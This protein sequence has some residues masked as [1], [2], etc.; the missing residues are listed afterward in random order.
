M[1]A[2]TEPD[3]I[4]H[5]GESGGDLRT[6]LNP[7]PEIPNQGA[8]PKPNNPPNLA[9]PAP[10]R[11][12][13]YG[14]TNKQ[15]RLRD[16][17]RKTTFYSQNIQGSGRCKATDTPT[18]KFDHI[19]SLMKAKGID[20]YLVQ[21][22]WLSNEYEDSSDINGFYL[23]HHGTDEEHEA[24]DSNEGEDEE[25]PH[26][27]NKRKQ[28]HT[29]GG[30]AIF[31]SPRAKEAWKRAGQQDPITSGNI[32]GCARFISISL[33]FLD[34][35][36]KTIKVNACSI[37]HPTDVTQ[38]ERSD[39]LSD[40][41]SLYDTLD[42]DNH[43]IISGCDANAS[44]GNRNSIYANRDG[45]VEDHE[46]NADI[47]G[48]FGLDHVNEAGLELSHLMKSKKLAS[49]TS[50]FE[51]KTYT[52]WRSFSK[53]NE[54]RAQDGEP[55]LTSPRRVQFQLDLFLTQKHNLKSIL[56]AKRVGDGAP[57]D[58]S[59]VKLVLRLA[60][61]LVMKNSKFNVK[62]VGKGKKTAKLDW[63]LLRN[64]EIRANYNYK[65]TTNLQKKKY[66]YT[67]S[68]AIPTAE[69][70]YTDFM[71]A[72]MQAAE[73]TIQGPG[74]VSKDWFQHSEAILNEAIRLRNYWSSVWMHTTL[75]QARQKFREARSKL[76]KAIKK[77]KAVWID[78]RA[79]EIHDMKFDPKSAWMAVREVE[80]GFEGHYSA[81]GDIKMR[82]PNGDIAT[83]DREN[84]DVMAEH[85]KKVFNN[86]RPIDISVLDEL[87]QREII[88]ELGLPPTNEEFAAA[89]RKIANGKSPG[90]SGITPEA[91]KNLDYSHTRTLR[92]FLREYWT[93]PNVDYEEWHRNSLCALRKAGKGKDYS[94][95]NNWR[96]ICLAEIPAK[97]QSSII[98]NR[99]L[100][101][102]EKVGIETQYGCVPGKGCTDALYAIKTALQIRKQHGKDTWAVFVD[103][104]KAFDTAD[105]SLL[106]AIL[107][108][109]GIPD[110]LISVIEKMY[111]DSIVSFKIGSESRDIKYGIG[112]KQG[113]NM[114]P[115]L[116]IYLMNAFAETLADKWKFDKLEFRW[117]PETSSVKK[118]GRL[119]GQ[120]PKTLGTKFDLFYFLYVDDGAM[121]FDN[122]NDLIEGTRLI[123]NHFARFGLEMHIG[124][125]EKK[126][127]TECV[128]F[129]AFESEYEDKDTSIFE[130][131]D[132]FVQF[133]KQFKYLGSIISF[134][135]N[136]SID[137][138]ARISQASKAM[139][140]L[141]NFF[142]CDKVS[143]YAKRLIY[144]AIPVNLCL[145]GAE[146]WALTEASLRKL[147]VFHTRSIR[148]ILKITIYDVKE[149][150]IKNDDILSMFNLPPMENMVAKRQLRWAGKMVRM[151]ESRLPIK[152]LAC[153]MNT[154]RP[155]RRPHTTTRN[156][157]IR[158]LQIMDPNISRCGTLNEW[159]HSAKDESDWNERLAGLDPTPS[160]S[161]T[162]ATPEQS[163]GLDPLS[164]TAYDTT[165][166]PGFP[167]QLEPDPS[168]GNHRTD[169][170]MTTSFEDIPLQQTWAC[171]LYSPSNLWSTGRP[172]PPNQ[173]P[174]SVTF[175]ESPSNLLASNFRLGTEDFESWRYTNHRPQPLVIP[176]S[177]GYANPAPSPLTPLEH[178]LITRRPNLPF[179]FL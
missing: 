74:R 104:V 10:S 110:S 107:K 48:P 5:D 173:F 148:S 68:V 111:K 112:V 125:G 51:H 24:S 11:V 23:F 96:G 153:W 135:L 114:A 95:P 163:D 149:L 2:P 62:R 8:P 39:F 136:D 94:D 79:E 124:R 159:F 161:P 126:S 54:E 98:S 145:W 165:E 20:V 157:L 40:L 178:S 129:P 138:D 143:L 131:N 81:Q 47:I 14:G 168:I 127:K 18:Y 80:K 119:T 3:R 84:A 170:R 78:K 164:H 134:N 41:D 65:L 179:F 46:D 6:T 37:Y 53:T 139:G 66:F 85:F 83:N 109:Y 61:K 43:I 152:M 52:T 30:V 132:G 42:T 88:S 117:F 100:L 21:E 123:M 71:E 34:H 128:L 103:L 155:S 27:Q 35:L 175:L 49:A 57:S 60:S 144:L 167:S 93:N 15:K 77:A 36:N 174:T 166:N 63:R 64:D 28:G 154:P 115:V 172:T 90:E 32:L 70:K 151:D 169:I 140:A 26:L 75:P 87:E 150:H 12:S 4:P 69:S 97:I 9:V 29:R 59:A 58:H 17:L 113:D 44:I 137:I 1:T 67:N 82:K 45:T 92:E 101:H 25:N 177:L 91:L 121:L 160:V 56:D 133:T 86:H 73:D 158:S 176:N 31:L 13:P 106:F 118:K 89:L 50:F 16:F 120:S 156:S 147:K 130:V 76:E 116:F 55:I 19:T 102:L 142:K 108:K 162:S 99:L 141:R 22:T 38:Q 7:E 105:H 146:S 72:T 33:H 171:E 122:R